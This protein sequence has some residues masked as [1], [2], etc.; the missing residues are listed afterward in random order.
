MTTQSRRT[1]YYAQSVV[2][3]FTMMIMQGVSYAQGTVNQEKT[4][5]V[6]LLE[7]TV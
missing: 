3:G 4:T 5:P 1:K 2:M 6:S 7:V